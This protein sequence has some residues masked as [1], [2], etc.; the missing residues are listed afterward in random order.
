MPYYH[1]LMVLTNAR[2]EDEAMM[3]AT[4]NLV[5]KR[6]PT[7]FFRVTLVQKRIVKC[8]GPE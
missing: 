2:S 7:V 3:A 4:N 1:W 5:C 6:I 8:M